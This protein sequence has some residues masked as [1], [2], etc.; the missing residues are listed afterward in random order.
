MGSTFN[1]FT[2]ARFFD[3]IVFD[4]FH[5]ISDRSFGMACLL[6]LVAVSERKGKVSLLSATPINIIK[7]LQQVGIPENEV[8][9][10]SEEIVD[11][12]P[13]GNRPIH[14]EVMIV[15]ENCSH[16]V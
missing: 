3:H 6:G 16:L 8:D 14:G 10:I 7:I 12:L 9:I 2:Y 13:E 15:V 4:E 11:G 1:P 5:T